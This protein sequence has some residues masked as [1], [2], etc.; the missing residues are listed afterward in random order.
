MGAKDAQ[1]SADIL[2]VDDVINNLRLLSYTLTKHGYKVRKVINGQMAL[3]AAQAMPPDLILLDVCM[4]GIDGF[5]VCQQLKAHAV[6]CEIPIIFLTALDQPLD[7]VKGFELGGNDY[8]TKPFEVSEVLVRVK[9]QLQMSRL[10]AELKA[11]NEQL[12]QEISDRLTAQAALHTLNQ[13]LEAKVQAST[14]HLRAANQQLFDL[15]LKLRENLTQTE[16]LSALKSQLITTIA[17][18]FRNPLSVIITATELLQ[19]ANAC[20]LAAPGSSQVT[21]VRCSEQAWEDDSLNRRSP[22]PQH[23]PGGTLSSYPQASKYLQ[24]IRESATR[25][26]NSLKEVLTLTDTQT[27]RLQMSSVPINLSHFCQTLVERYSCQ[28]QSKAKLLFV[29][30]GVAHEPIYADLFLLEQI[31]S[32]LLT[33]ALSYSPNGGEVCLE[34]S[35]E[36]TAAIFRIRDA[37]IGIPIAE[38]SKIFEQFYRASNTNTLPGTPGI[39]LGLAIV[40]QAVQVYGG[41]ITVSSQVNAGTTVTVVIPLVFEN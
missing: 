1:C 33:N 32:H 28:T 5:E 13:E 11:K 36:P 22:H 31:L 15:Q 3:N 35:Y 19:T 17:H 30:L 41:Q 23:L 6:T 7:K 12:Q 18:E 9:H 25:I 4:P 34:L 40:K 14:A 20:S 37:G 21:P 29:Q 38:Q 39:G 2:I 27:Q 16:E 10:Q 24:M 8:I 26:N